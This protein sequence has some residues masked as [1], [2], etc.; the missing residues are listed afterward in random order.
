[1]KVVFTTDGSPDANHAIDEGLRLLC[2]SPIEAWVVTVAERV[3]ALVA[4]E[5]IGSG[6]A[7]AAAKDRLLHEEIV[8]EAIARLA[9]LGFEATGEVR[10]GDPASEILAFAHEVGA[11]L[12]VVGSHGRGALGRAMLGSVSTRVAHAWPGPVLVVRPRPQP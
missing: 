10:V 7:V 2:G 11:E 4:L 5:A 9:A 3:P 1:M 12:I 8:V 6:V